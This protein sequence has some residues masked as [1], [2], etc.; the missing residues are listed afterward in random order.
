MRVRIAQRKGGTP[1]VWQIMYPNG[2][3]AETDHHDRLLVTGGG[4]TDVTEGGKKGWY[5]I[6]V[7]EDTAKTRKSVGCDSA[8]AREGRRVEMDVHSLKYRLG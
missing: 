2:K 8:N 3:E 4:W 7:R 1:F 5:A 6:C